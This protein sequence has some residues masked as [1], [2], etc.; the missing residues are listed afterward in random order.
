MLLMSNAD[1]NVFKGSGEGERRKKKVSVVS[2][3]DK[4]TERSIL[5]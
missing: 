4:D 2:K 3:D 1:P 5:L